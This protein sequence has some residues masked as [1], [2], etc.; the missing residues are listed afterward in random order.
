MRN[1]EEYKTRDLAEAAALITY[2][3]QISKIERI[4]NICFFVFEN[5][6]L[7]ESISKKYFFGELLVNA[8]TYYE[9]I[10]R[11]KTIIFR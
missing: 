3:I 5:I 6:G 1:S 10:G 4:K 2:G 9:S 11:L 7:C 8:R